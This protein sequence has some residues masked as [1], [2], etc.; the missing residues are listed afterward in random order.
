VDGGFRR[1]LNGY[2][3]ILEPLSRLVVTTHS[4]LYGFGIVMDF[5]IVNGSLDFGSQN[6]RQISFADC[7]I[8]L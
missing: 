8:H 7:T 4:A 1:A 3:Q 5:E 6:M 2:K